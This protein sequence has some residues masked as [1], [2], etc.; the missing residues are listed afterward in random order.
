MYKAE[1]CCN[2][3]KKRPLNENSIL[4]ILNYLW[5]MSVRI[6]RLQKASM[7]ESFGKLVKSIYAEEPLWYHKTSMEES[8]KKVF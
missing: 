5:S 8:F 7:E 2:I 6:M 1:R 3:T 4:K